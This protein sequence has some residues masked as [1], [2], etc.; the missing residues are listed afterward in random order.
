MSKSDIQS[1]LSS[2]K[3][4]DD[5]GSGSLDTRWKRD[6][7]MEEWPNSMIAAQNILM[8]GKTTPRTSFLHDEL[9]PLAK[10]GGICFT[11]VY[12]AFRY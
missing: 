10:H 12:P 9:L 4:F 8:E 6:R 2:A 1:W 5:D 11:A 3:K 7:V